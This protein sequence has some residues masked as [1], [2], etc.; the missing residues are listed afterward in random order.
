MSDG[1]ASV[2]GDLGDFTPGTVRVV[3]AAEVE[4]RSLGHARIGTEHLLLAL[5]AYDGGV[6]SQ[7]LTAAGVSLAPVR[8]KVVEAVGA[9]STGTVQEWTPR[10]VRAVGRAPRFARDAGMALVHS[11]HLML[12]VLDVE[13]TAGQVLRGL[14]VDIDQLGEALRTARAADEPVPPADEVADPLVDTEPVTTASPA[15]NCWH[16]GIDLRPGVAATEVP[17]TGHAVQALLV[18]CP[19]CGTLL[20]ALPAPDLED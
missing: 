3:G 8:R 15:V 6:A 20:G 4:A 2:V 10:A 18:S 17:V 5:L 16:C 14:G 1:S 19:G 13:G 11:E 12:A 9:A 7:V